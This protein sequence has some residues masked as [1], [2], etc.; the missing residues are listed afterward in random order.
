M[1]SGMV[2]D[3]KEFAVLDGPGI[4]TTVF[5][6]G[7]PLRC[8]WCHNPEGLRPE[9]QRIRGQVGERIAG[10]RY[11][12]DELAGLLNRQA[13][14]LRAGEGGV[15]FS[16][17][18][19]LTQAPFVTAVMERLEGIHTVLDTS[20]YGD[21]EAFSLL[22]ERVD[23]VLFDLKLMD[24]GAHCRYTGVENDRILDNLTRLDAMRTPV[25]IRVPL[26]PGITDTEENLAAIARRAA[27]LNAIERVELL[28]Y[29]RAAG[30][31]YAACGMR[32]EPPYD[33]PAA[34]NSH[35]DVFKKCNLSVV[36]A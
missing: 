26:I 6:K 31:K 16:G 36:V 23:L 2:F 32:F 3:I 34:P 35:L 7:C 30:G 8:C 17:G 33:E 25:I 12:A 1:I 27:C 10:R 28:A 20:G 4:R 9:P 29:N 19:P 13:E 24:T 15:T 14:A 11:A 5:L 21:P 18:E 22:A